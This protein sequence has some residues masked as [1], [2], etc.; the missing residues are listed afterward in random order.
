[1]SILNIINQ[2]AATDKT[3]LKEK[4]LKESASNETLKECFYL[5]YCKQVTFGV[6]KYDKPSRYSSVLSLSGALQVFKNKLATRQV[7]GNAALQ[8][9][10]DTLNCLSDVDD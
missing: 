7:T 10:T 3:S 6:K 5:A 8:L 1:M 4:I 9:V 2:L